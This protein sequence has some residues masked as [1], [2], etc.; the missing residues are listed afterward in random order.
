M[1]TNKCGATG[2]VMIGDHHAGQ[3]TC[4]LDES[5]VDRKRRT[6]HDFGGRSGH[7]HRCTTT[8]R[9]SGEFDCT[10]IPATPHRITLEWFDVAEVPD[11]ALFDPN[12]TFD[13]E[14]PAP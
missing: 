10:P 13:V 12:E 14:V 8:R 3:V 2:A 6:D 5:H 1:T 4:E 9:R 7:C 11:L